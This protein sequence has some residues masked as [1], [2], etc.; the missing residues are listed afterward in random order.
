MLCFVA[1]TVMAH[2]KYTSK[3]DNTD[4]MMILKNKRLLRKYFEC[5]MERGPCT[6]DGK[7]LKKHVRDAI[8]TGC[9]KCTYI[10]EQKAIQI[11]EYL[12]KHELSMWKQLTAKYDPTGE[13]RQKYE[14]SIAVLSIF[15]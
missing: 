1:V 14:D 4:V 2:K 13:W 8:Q 11:V 15:E 10:Q 7:E 3:F 5:V 9:A 6:M 12:M